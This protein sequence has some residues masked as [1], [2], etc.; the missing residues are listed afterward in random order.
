MAVGAEVVAPV[1]ELP[2]PADAEVG[3]DGPRPFDLPQR[4]HDRRHEW[5][6]YVGLFW[7]SP[8]AAHD[9]QSGFSSSHDAARQVEEK[10]ANTTSRIVARC[11]A[12]FRWMTATA[13][14]VVAVLG[15][16]GSADCHCLRSVG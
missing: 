14:H 9:A 15:R 5:S 7:H 3:E 8:A 1:R 16:K 13:G 2:S 6:I 4:P 10:D 11:M 12:V